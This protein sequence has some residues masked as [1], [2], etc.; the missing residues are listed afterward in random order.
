MLLCL[1]AVVAVSAC[2]DDR[3]QQTAAPGAAVTAPAPTAAST[4][5]ATTTP[6]ATTATSTPVVPQSLAF[7][8]P[9]VGGGTIDLADYAGTPV[10]L[11]FWAPT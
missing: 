2:G 4:T 3:V 7:T 11:W 9:R 8:A 1:I 10:L 6:A 5:P